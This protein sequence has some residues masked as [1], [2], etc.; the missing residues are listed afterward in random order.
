MEAFAVL[1]NAIFGIAFKNS[2]VELIYRYFVNRSEEFPSP[3]NSFFFEVVSKRPIA[4]H[5]KHG[6][7]VGVY[8]NF[9]EV[10]V[11]TRNAQA[12]L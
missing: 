4:K 1:G 2:D 12:F 7:V 10:V 8:T 6:V 5:F 3:A 9:F 11:F